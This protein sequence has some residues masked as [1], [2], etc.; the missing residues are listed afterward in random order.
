MAEH[1]QACFWLLLGG[2]G[3]W[4]ALRSL[5]EPPMVET[6]PLELWLGGTA[7][8]EREWNP[9]GCLTDKGLIHSH[10]ISQNW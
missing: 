2:G 4:I 7:D 6:Q 8:E 1:I 9:A 5:S 10:F 3:A